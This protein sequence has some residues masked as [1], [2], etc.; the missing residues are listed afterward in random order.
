MM[1]NLQALGRRFAL[2]RVLARMLIA[3]LPASGMAAGIEV[4]LDREVLALGDTAVLKV[5]VQGG[6]GRDTPR[7]PD[8]PGLRF[9]MTGNGMSFSFENGRQSVISEITYAVTAS[10]VGEYGIGPVSVTLGGQRVQSDRLKLTVVP[11]NDPKAARNDGLDQAAFLRLVLP[12]RPVYVGESF[13]AEIH[14]YAVGGRLQQGPQL[15]ADGCTLGKIQD[16]GQQGNVRVNNRIYTRARFLQ[17]VTAARSG[18]L[19]LQAAN[20]ILDV[21]VQ[22]RETPTSPF[23]DIFN[24]RENRRLNLATEPATLRVLPL[25]KEG[26]PPGFKGAVGDFRI[27]V[28]ASPTNVHAGDPVTVRIEVQGRGNFDSVQLPD[29][30]AWRGFRL[31]PPTAEFET[32]DP[33]GLV[34]TKRFEQVVTPESADLTS[35]PAFVF[36]FFHPESQSYKTVRAASIPLRV[37]AGAA[38]PVIPMAETRTEP[39]TASKTDLVPL[40][41]HLGLVMAPA[42]PWATQPWFVLLSLAPPVVWSG[43]R[44][45]RGWRG[46]RDADQAA[47]RRRDLEQRVAKGLAA[48]P[49]LARDAGSEAFFA[50]LFRTLQ[51]AVALR[52]GEAPASVTEGSIDSGLSRSGVTP[53]TLEALHRLFQACNQA[54]YANVGAV[55]DLQQ[56]ANEARTLCERLAAKPPGS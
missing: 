20:C 30:P 33:S 14:L 47:R 48:L 5:T 54:R 51:E 9:A 15:A 8:V 35:L 56:L 17:T 1:P 55:D 52:T 23:D 29:Q 31:Y 16:G 22:R 39:E 44:L 38:A 40:K 42:S 27:A 3:W 4:S 37:E 2:A 18:E 50:S 10:K 34:G 53:E 13:A 6:S 46:R 7:I 36:S 11:A 28:S 12:D 43:S 49:V 45:W 21:P 32:Q 26:V 19:T 41:A 25:P 24:L